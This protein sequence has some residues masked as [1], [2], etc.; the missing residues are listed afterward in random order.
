MAPLVKDSNLVHHMGEGIAAAGA[1]VDHKPLET[2]GKGMVDKSDDLAQGGISE[3][4]KGRAGRWYGKMKHN[5]KG[6]TTATSREEKV[7][8]RNRVIAAGLLAAGAVLCH[9]G[10]VV[11]VGAAI[12]PTTGVETAADAAQ[13]Q[14]DNRSFTTNIGGGQF[15]DSS[16][17]IDEQLWAAVEANGGTRPSGSPWENPTNLG[18]S[19]RHQ[20]ELAG[21]AGF[22]AGLSLIVAGAARNRRTITVHAPA[23][24]LSRNLEQP[25]LSA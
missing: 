3:A 12:A 2:I 1:V 15:I 13:Q 16:L 10:V 22:A 23:A 6:F 17:E 24:K 11:T 25:G 4:D 19:H 20:K 8:H 21:L 5:V 7:A 9:G 14:L 18:I